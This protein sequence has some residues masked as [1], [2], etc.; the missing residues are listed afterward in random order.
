VGRRENELDPNAGA[1]A[2]F[3]A[4]LRDLRRAAGNLSYREL[5]RRAHYSHNTLST[6]T[7]GRALPSKAVTLAFVEACGGDRAEWLLRWQQVGTLAAAPTSRAAEKP[8]ATPPDDAEWRVPAQLPGAVPGFTGR[9]AHL[10]EL[11]A[12][13][14]RADTAQDAAVNVTVVHGGAGMGKSA[15]A[16]HWAHRTAAKFPGGQLYANLHGHGRSA[17][18]SPYAVLAGF[19]HALG[20][21]PRE[22]PADLERAAALFRT[23]V[24]GRSLLIVLDDA[25]DPG[26]VRPLLPGSPACAVLITSRDALAGLVATHGARRVAVNVLEPRESRELLTRVLGHWR[27][28]GQHSAMDEVARLCAHVPLALRIAAANL[29]D[30]TDR[31]IAEYA[32]QLGQGD[33]LAALALPGDEEAAVRAAFDLS[34]M[35]LAPEPQRLF[36]LFGLIPGTDLTLP[37]VAALTEQTGY[38]AAQALSRLESA[39]LVERRR[40]ERYS[41][42]DLLRLYARDLALRTDSEGSRTAALERLAEFY[43]SRSDAA[44]R[45]LYPQILR[46]SETQHSVVGAPAEAESQ[47]P[48]EA[49]AWLDT[50][51]HNLVATAR[52]AAEHGPYRV[53]WLFADV[54][55]GYFWLR[56]TPAEWLAVAQAGVSAADRSTGDAAARAAAYLCLADASLSSARREQAVAAYARAR[57]HAAEAHWPQAQAASLSNLASLHYSEGALDEA[58]D[59]YGA[60]LDV[61]RRTG[62]TSAQASALNGLGLV[63]LERGRYAEALRHCREALDLW[64]GTSSPGN[65]AIALNNMCISQCALGD[66]AA[67]RASISEALT[68]I[69]Q[70]ADTARESAAHMSLATLHRDQGRLHQALDEST[71]AVSLARQTHSATIEAYALNNLA[72]SQL[73]LGLPEAALESSHRALAL[74]RA[75]YP[76][77]RIEALL[78]AA[79]A[80]LELGRPREALDGALRG[81]Q[82]AERL[83]YRILHARALT[84]LA[85]IMLRGAV[86]DVR[87]AA[88]HA[89]RALDIYADCGHV[90]GRARALSLLGEAARDDNPALANEQWQNAMALYTSVGAPKAEQVKAFLAGLEDA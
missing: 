60:A 47:D 86:P 27:V 54:L 1:V 90:L 36:R 38:Q 43:L 3:A 2:R 5:A 4:E 34:Y 63:Q 71:H 51:L 44:A 48:A 55:R 15:L 37:A 18:E 81:A 31:L 59:A 50:E 16:L 14:L 30:H 82:Q 45:Q 62:R 77:P 84:L 49:A 67:A 76:S 11:D 69:R 21:P 65:V 25:A 68:L 8:G 88:G 32:G 17:P 83:G 57:D 66:P 22:I 78:G 53:A 13:V 6:A 9:V 89:E 24:A 35:R 80:E 12:L 61:A 58:L 33:R 56:G 75:A 40:P 10:R 46:L 42:H 52:W 41:L 7:N 64:R 39:H 29:H 20:T 19:L 26:Q 23:Q 72:S 74:V 85:E 28:D 87:E 70:I 79:A 73:R